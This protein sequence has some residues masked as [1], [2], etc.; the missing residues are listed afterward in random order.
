MRASRDFD[1]HHLH[2]QCTADDSNR[3]NAGLLR[4]DDLANLVVL[5]KD[6]HQSV[7]RGEWKISGWI[8][9]SEGRELQWE[10]VVERVRQVWQK[11]VE[12][13]EEQM[14]FIGEYYQQVTYR[15]WPWLLRRLRWKHGIS[16]TK[17]T[18]ESIMK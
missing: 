3:V 2:E 11:P 7:H 18:I 13:T 16:T 1:T 12:F 8:T 9:T 14:K 10:D 15:G 4:R 17:K 6:C 5:C